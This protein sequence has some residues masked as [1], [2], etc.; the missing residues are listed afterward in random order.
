M[1]T[2]NDNAKDK[3][4]MQPN[5][6][7][8]DETEDPRLLWNTIEEFLLFEAATLTWLSAPSTSTTSSKKI[9]LML[10]TSRGLGIVYDNASV[11]TQFLTHMAPVCD[12]WDN[13]VHYILATIPLPLLDEVI[14]QLMATRQLMKVTNKPH[15][16]D[17]ERPYKR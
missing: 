9:P 2:I 1:S 12:T 16:D 15:P 17:M 13:K 6:V 8:A 7:P 4:Q 14:E 3:L 10:S 11:V 5:Y